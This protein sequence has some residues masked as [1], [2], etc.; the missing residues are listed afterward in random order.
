MRG[1]APEIDADS[2][3]HSSGRGANARPDFT[4]TS[5]FCLQMGAAIK[6]E[7]ACIVNG[8]YDFALIIEAPPG[9]DV[10]LSCPV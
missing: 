3:D 4:E 7:A 5:L 10:Q 6:D 2:V 8:Q 9:T 1:S